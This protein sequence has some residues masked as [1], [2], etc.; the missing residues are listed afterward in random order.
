M[1]NEEFIDGLHHPVSKE[2]AISC[3]EYNLERLEQFRSEAIAEHEAGQW[4][5]YPENKPNKQGFYLVSRDRTVGKHSFILVSQEAWNGEEWI[6]L[7]K[8]S[9]VIAFRELPKPYQP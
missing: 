4:N 3:R 8:Y 1:T 7:N 5:K 6:I 9:E 2:S